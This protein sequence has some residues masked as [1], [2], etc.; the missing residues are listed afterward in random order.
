MLESFPK[1]MTSLAELDL[2][3]KLERSRMCTHFH[4]QETPEHLGRTVRQGLG[5]LW[6]NSCPGRSRPQRPELEVWPG[7]GRPTVQGAG[8]TRELGKGLHSACPSFQGHT[9]SH[10]RVVAKQVQ[11]PNKQV[12]Q[13]LTTCPSSEK[14]WGSLK[15]RFPGPQMSKLERDDS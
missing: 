13:K 3:A 4:A 15:I 11:L 6:V 12:R 7:H 8:C 5:A 2:T 10:A 1:S 9:N 14:T